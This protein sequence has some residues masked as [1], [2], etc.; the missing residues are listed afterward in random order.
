MN[1]IKVN[2][3]L[4]KGDGQY[5]LGHVY[6]LDVARK[7]DTVDTLMVISPEDNLIEGNVC[8][9]GHMKAAWIKDMGVPVFIVPESVE[10]AEND[11]TSEAIV[12]GTV[13]RDLVLRKTHGGRQ[14]VT[15]LLVT[16]EGQIPVLLWNGTAKNAVSRYKAGDKVRIKGRLQSRTYKSRKTNDKTTYELSAGRIDPVKGE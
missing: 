12:T 5:E 10:A 4:R 11:G 13:K 15:L 1:Q 8:V 7:S 9:K 2:G 6:W 16:D 3:N 14:I